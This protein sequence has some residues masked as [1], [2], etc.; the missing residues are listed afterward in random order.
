MRWRPGRWRPSSPRVYFGYAT[1][2]AEA[3]IVSIGAQGVQLR[4]GYA[5]SAICS[6]TRTALLTG[7]YQYRFPIGVE[8]PLGPGAPAGIGVPLVAV[9][10]PS[11]TPTGDETVAHDGALPLPLVLRNCPAVPAASRASWVVLLA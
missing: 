11:A 3:P 5:N 8:E 2:P 1:P 6:P 4:Q 10:R 9:S 7:C